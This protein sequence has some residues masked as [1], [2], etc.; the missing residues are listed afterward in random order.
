MIKNTFKENDLV[1]HPWLGK[2]RIFDYDDN[3]S[4]VKVLTTDLK[5]WNIKRVQTR[6]LTKLK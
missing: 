6:T 4:L 5:K 2:V 1:L 3:Y